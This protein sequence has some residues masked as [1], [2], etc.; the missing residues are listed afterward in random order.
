MPR[1]YWLLVVAIVLALTAGEAAYWRIAAGRLRNGYQAWLAAQAPRGWEIGSGPVSI[2]GWPGSAS[3]TIPNLALRHAGPTMPGD[4][5][6]ASAGVTLA[7]SLFN[8]TALDLSL[9]GPMHI[10]VAT[11]PDT[12]VT[13]D[14]TTAAVPLR[15]T[16]PL[17]AALHASGLRWKP[18]RVPGM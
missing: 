6:V 11:L 12:I 1:K 14:E 16:G 17:S 5:E 18:P 9:T 10:R 15:R 7:V 4:V 8:P 2:G 13:G 3:V